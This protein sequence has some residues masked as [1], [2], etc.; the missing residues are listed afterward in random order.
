MDTIHW[1]IFLSKQDVDD[2][3]LSDAQ[4]E[5]I[6]DTIG[7]IAIVYDKILEFERYERGMMRVREKVAKGLLQEAE[8]EEV[9]LGKQF[10]EFRKL[11]S[12]LLDLA[13]KSRHEGF[14]KGAASK[15]ANDR[16]IHCDNRFL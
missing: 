2:V 6:L 15:P 7:S 10:P 8:A 12:I 5:Q 9:E 1:W 16:L 3:V 4:F 11:R 14:H 13:S